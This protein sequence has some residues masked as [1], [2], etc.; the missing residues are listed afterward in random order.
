MIGALLVG[1]TLFG[2]LPVG[3]APFGAAKAAGTDAKAASGA[4]T[5]GATT[6]SATASGAT[7]GTGDAAAA[8]ALLA[9]GEKAYAPCKPC[10]TV[11]AGGGDLV[12]PNLHGL[13]GRRSGTKPGFRFSDAMTKAAILWDEATIDQYLQNPRGY[14]PG[15]RMAFFGIAKPETRAA[16]I[17]WLK[18]AT[19]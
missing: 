7:T 13:F 9:A 6:G 5:G 3:I 19:K 2:T 4:T 14:I 8:A 12:G 11:T 1:A 10:H 16:L 17:A 15:N 18:Q